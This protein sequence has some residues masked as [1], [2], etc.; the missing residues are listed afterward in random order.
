MDRQDNQR[1]DRSAE[2]CGTIQNRQAQTEVAPSAFFLITGAHKV[3]LGEE[4]NKRKNVK[5]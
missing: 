3:P 4:E 1:Q 5:Y 2:D